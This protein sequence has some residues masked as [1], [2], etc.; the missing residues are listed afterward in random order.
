VRDRNAAAN[1]AVLRRIA[2]N[3]VR[4][5]I[6]RTGSLEGKRKMAGRDDGF[7]HRLVAP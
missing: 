7:M 4:A 5:D 6:S 1:L 3:L 2:L